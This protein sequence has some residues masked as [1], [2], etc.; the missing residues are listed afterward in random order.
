MSTDGTE[1]YF[2]I[3]YP[4]RLTQIATAQDDGASEAIAMSQVLVWASNLVLRRG[5]LPRLELMPGNVMLPR[6]SGDFDGFSGGP[7]FSVNSRTMAIE[8]RGIVIRGGT[9]KLFFGSTE[10]VQKLCHLALSQPQ[11]EKVAA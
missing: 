11:I 8:L 5:D 6:C 3:G 9:D 4:T 2:A 7:V 10:W 1:T